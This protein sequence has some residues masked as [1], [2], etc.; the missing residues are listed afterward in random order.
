MGRFLCGPS[1]HG[2]SWF[3][4]ELSCIQLKYIVL[5]QNSVAPGQLY[6]SLGIS[7][8]PLL[9]NNFKEV[10]VATLT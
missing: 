7:S 9:I 10:N 4:A 3:W 6:A 5:I 1:W 8:S 2:L